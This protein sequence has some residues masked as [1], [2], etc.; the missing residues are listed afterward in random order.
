MQVALVD[1]G[2]ANFRSVERALQAAADLRGSQFASQL[3]VTRSHDPDFVAS[4]DKILVPGQGGFGDCVRALESRAMDTCVKECIARGTPFFGICLGL[5]AL[6]ESSPEAPGV[7]GLGIIAGSC[8][9]LVPEGG[10]KIPHMGW[11][12]L[13][14]EHGGH[15]ILGAEAG[16]GPWVYFVHSFHG[17]PEDPHLVKASVQHGRHRITAAVAKDNV[18]ATQFHPEKS[19][20]VGLEMLARFLDS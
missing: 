3:K 13:E 2:H 1:T 10:A 14:L 4:C 19:Q 11:N 20:R 16:P 18:V 17:V 8:Q 15:G 7:P 12:R 5:Q 6:F 9:E